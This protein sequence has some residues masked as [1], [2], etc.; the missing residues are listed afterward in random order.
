MH[1]ELEQI[2]RRLYIT[3]TQTLSILN[4]LQ[5]YYQLLY[6]LWLIFTINHTKF[7]TNRKMGVAIAIVLA[8]LG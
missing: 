6:H 8:H 1:F 4:T 3:P 7:S 2:E 5:N